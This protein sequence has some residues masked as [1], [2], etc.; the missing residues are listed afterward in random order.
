MLTGK[1]IVELK[2]HVSSILVILI[3][4][5]KTVSADLS[6]QQVLNVCYSTCEVFTDFY[7]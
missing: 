3:I 7:L 2:Q 5:C 4:S 6:V 1:V